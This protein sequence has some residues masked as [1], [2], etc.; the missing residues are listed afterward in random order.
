[1]TSGTDLAIVQNYD[2]QVYKVANV[3]IEVTFCSFQTQILH[4]KQQSSEGF[5]LRLSESKVRMV[6]T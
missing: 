5:E 4:K 3:S 1:M 6:T 2:R